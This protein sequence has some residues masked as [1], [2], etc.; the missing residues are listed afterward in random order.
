MIPLLWILGAPGDLRE[1]SG[2][3]AIRRTPHEP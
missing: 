3:A 2:W 1:E